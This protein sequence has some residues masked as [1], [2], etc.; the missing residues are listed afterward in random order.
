M[1]SLGQISLFQNDPLL[2]FISSNI[3]S[4]TLI[5]PLMTATRRVQCQDRIAG[6]LP[7]RYEGVWHA[8]KLIAAEEGIRGLFRG[9]AAFLPGVRLSLALRN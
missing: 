4:Q 9:Y 8:L 5:Y 6:M 2:A 3:I 1:F 7:I